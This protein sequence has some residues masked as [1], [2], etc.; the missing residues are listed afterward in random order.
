MMRI[1]GCAPSRVCAI[2][3]LFGAPVAG[4]AAQSQSPSLFAA[5]TVGEAL[6]ENGVAPRMSIIRRA[7]RE[8]RRVVSRNLDP[9]LLTKAQGISGSDFRYEFPGSGRTAHLGVIVLTYPD[10]VLA[11]RMAAVLAPREQYFGG[12]KILI[13]FSAISL[14]NLLVVVYSESSG[15]DR[16]VKAISNLPTIF[17]KVSATEGVAWNESGSIKTPQ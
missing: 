16:I 6:R 9:Q 4:F 1:L 2:L 11:K 10:A 3:I 14:S 7:P 17:E 13:Y 15:D 8:L 5:N 12:S